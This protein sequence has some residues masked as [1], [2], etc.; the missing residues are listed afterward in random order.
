[1]ARVRLR[2]TQLADAL[3]L[4]ALLGDGLARRGHLGVPTRTSAHTYPYNLGAA[5]SGLGAV[6]EL[7]YARVG[8]V[9]LGKGGFR[10]A[11]RARHIVRLP[12]TV[13]VLIDSTKGWSLSSRKRSAARG[14]RDRAAACA[15]TRSRARINGSD[16]PVCSSPA[17]AN[18]LLTALLSGPDIVLQHPLFSLCSLQL[19]LKPT[20]HGLSQCAG[21]D[22][23]I[24]LLAY[25][26][27]HSPGRSFDHHRCR[28]MHIASSL[29]ELVNRWRLPRCELIALPPTREHHL[30]G[31]AANCSRAHDALLGHGWQG[32]RLHRP[33]GT[34]ASHVTVDVRQYYVTDNPC[35]RAAATSAWATLQYNTCSNHTVVSQPRAPPGRLTREHVLAGGLADELAHSALHA[36][37]RRVR[38]RRLATAGE[39]ALLRVEHGDLRVQ[40]RG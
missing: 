4:R 8:A 24:T 34:C 35:D 3:P 6:K 14:E 32:R 28:V 19:L 12:H 5:M 1:M 26:R 11:G 2:A 9:V 29:H 22:L 31:M 25:R 20:L 15:G 33:F 10:H 17:G 13:A 7:A 18:G 16:S 27:H 38:A 37:W 36:Q 21:G 40:S 30:I 39:E 23:I